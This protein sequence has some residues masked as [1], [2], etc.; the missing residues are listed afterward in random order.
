MP[1]VFSAKLDK[2]DSLETS[3]D[4]FKFYN[5]IFT[6]FAPRW[7]FKNKSPNPISSLNRCIPASARAPIFIL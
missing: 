1:T 4:C 3:S 7:N 5:H 2:K 6:S